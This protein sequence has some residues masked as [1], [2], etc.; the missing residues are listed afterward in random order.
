MGRL[1]NALNKPIYPLAILDRARSSV[2]RFA[3]NLAASWGWQGGYS[4]GSGRGYSGE[5]Y[6]GALRVYSS[7]SD[8]DA[9]A[10]R[11]RSRVAY[12]ES[13]QARASVRRIADS[14]VGTGLTARATPIWS[15]IGSTLDDEGKRKLA[16]EIDERF[17][18]WAN[19]HEP[20]A[21]GR[22]NLAEMQSFI[23]DNEL[24]DG[25]LPIILRYSGDS[26]RVSPLNLQVLDADQLD[27]RITTYGTPDKAGLA[28]AA[29]ERGNVLK[30]G[31]E[32]TGAGELVAIY[33]SS[34][35]K[36]FDPPTRVPVRGPIGRRFVLLPAILDLPGQIRGVGPLA[37]IVHDL[38]KITDYSTAEI[39][40]A[41]AN[42]LVAAV[43][44]PGTENDTRSKAA[45]IVGGRVT[46]TESST[47][48]AISRP[49]IIVD[50]LK[51]GETLQSYDT[52]RPNVNFGAFV[53]TITKSLSASLSTPVE[54]LEMTFSANYSASRA[55]IILFWN[56]VE[57]WRSH[58]VSQ[59]LQPVYEAWLR[60]EVSAGRLPTLKATGFGTDPVQTRAWLCSEWIGN[61]MPSIDP[62]K[63]ATA[64]DLRIAQGATTRE[65]NALEF[66]GSDFYDNATRQKREREAMPAPE[67]VASPFGAPVKSTPADDGEKKPD[68]EEGEE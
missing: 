14:V 9:R 3:R 60:E 63:D 18:L 46:A 20:D 61:P 64:A 59:F 31:L 26:S 53:S 19:S 11:S 39:A 54:V 8:L 58:L 48:A 15:L 44:Q 52:K 34:P 17:R 37:P 56:T 30:D 51:A 55:S 68:P 42:A 36:P 12:W 7:G 67:P 27:T 32:L 23:F 41:V 33:V 43:I 2:A 38:E 6:P 25:D 50:R 40:S 28:V 57:R 22:R 49:G 13:P 66:N 10:L 47:D 35:V 29:K 65:R 62:V 45:A 5:K 16:D 1:R 21:A 24:R 4:G